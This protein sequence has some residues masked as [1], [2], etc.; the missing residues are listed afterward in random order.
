LYVPEISPRLK[1][2][3]GIQIMSRVDGYRTSTVKS[4]LRTPREAETE[5]LGLM[6]AGAKRLANASGESAASAP[7]SPTAAET[8]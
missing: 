8:R 6:M 3:G 7:P 5:T 1:V 2:P 4:F